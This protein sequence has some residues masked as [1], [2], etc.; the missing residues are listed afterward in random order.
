MFGDVT[1][2][3]VADVEGG[4]ACMPSELVPTDADKRR[5]VLAAFG[6]ALDEFRRLNPTMPVAQIQTFLLAA[7]AD[8]LTMSEIAEKTGTK[9]ST[10]SRYLIDLGIPRTSEDTAYGLLERG[11]GVRDPRAAS[12]QM[13]RKGKALV[14]RLVSTLVSICESN[15]YVDISGK[16][17]R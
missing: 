2:P 13:S 12:Y 14:N 5:Q 11:M 8:E 3:T 1:F 15:H 17:G 10:T 16:K 9:V 7:I 6:K 4:I